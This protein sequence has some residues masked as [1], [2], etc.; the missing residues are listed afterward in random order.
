LGQKLDLGDLRYSTGLAMAWVSPV[1][2][3]RFSLGQA[4]NKKE[5]D[6]VERFQFQMGTTF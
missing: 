3:L 5:G 2:P 6:R 4:L 1:G